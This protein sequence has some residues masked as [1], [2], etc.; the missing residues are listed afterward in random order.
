MHKMS[1][2]DRMAIMNMVKDGSMTMDEAMSKV[3]AGKAQVR[4]AI[5]CC[6]ILSLFQLLL[7]R[8]HI[9]AYLVRARGKALANVYAF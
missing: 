1:D 8:F 9:D 7:E 4:L 2:L 6:V 5:T 3:A